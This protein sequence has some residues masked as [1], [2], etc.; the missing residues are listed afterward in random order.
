MIRSL[1]KNANTSAHAVFLPA[2][3]IHMLKM[4]D[5]IVNDNI[6]LYILSHLQLDCIISGKSKV[7]HVGVCNNCYAYMGMNG[8]SCTLCN[9]SKRHT[10]RVAE[11]DGD[12]VFDRADAIWCDDCT[13]FMYKHLKIKRIH[14]CTKYL[15]MLSYLVPTDIARV[16]MNIYNNITPIYV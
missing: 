6:V 15:M 2:L 11:Y 16:I 13:L 4:C 7:N 1:S 3:R 10:I 12:G 5:T 9:Q 8:G 14:K